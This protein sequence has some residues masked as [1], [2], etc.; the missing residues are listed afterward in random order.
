[1]PSPLGDCVCSYSATK[2][3]SFSAFL[4][5]DKHRLE[6]TDRGHT[7]EHSFHRQPKSQSANAENCG[8]GISV[9]HERFVKKIQPLHPHRIQL[10]K[11]QERSFATEY[12]F[13]SV[14][15]YIQHNL[16][17]LGPWEK[18]PFAIGEML[19]EEVCYFG[20][21]DLL[22]CLQQSLR[23]VPGPL[24]ITRIAVCPLQ[25]FSIDLPRLPQS[26]QTRKQP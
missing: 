13:P 2:Q 14:R 12:H 9:L 7:Y 6:T 8:E 24:P 26:S 16:V 23:Q 22:R 1:M 20:V 19:R 25:I 21:G 4:N 17:F 5:A 10:Y 3:Q 18:G 11:P 15:T